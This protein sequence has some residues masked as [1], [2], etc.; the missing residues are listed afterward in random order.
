AQTIRNALVSA[1]SQRDHRSALLHPFRPLRR[2]LGFARPINPTFISST[3]FK[4][5]AIRSV[6]LG[7]KPKKAA[8]GCRSPKRKRDTGAGLESRRFWSAAALC[9]FSADQHRMTDRFNHTPLKL[10][11][12]S[13]NDAADNIADLQILFSA[14]RMCIVALNTTGNRRAV[15]V[16]RG[17]IA[18]AT[19]GFLGIEVGFGMLDH[20]LEAFPL[21]GGLRA[22][23]RI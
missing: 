10:Q 7:W 11:R 23:L 1:R 13:D 5:G 21:G 14:A 18:P 8:E 15:G 19:Q 2:F 9:H 6:G 4:T 3:P 16:H 20:G 22:I 12:D 17:E